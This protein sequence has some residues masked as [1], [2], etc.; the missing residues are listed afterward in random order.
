M[1]SLCGMLG[2]D[3]HWTE[4]SGAPAVF[5][6][7]SETHTRLRERQARTRLV[8]IVLA[9][10]GLKLA[11]WS[12]NAYLLSSRTGRTSI[13]DNLSQLWSEAEKLCGR[14]CDPLDERLIVSLRGATG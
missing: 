9:H 3:A 5:A 4:S 10:Y 7:R 12:G 8:N 1:C 13:V 6:N 14:P 11:D 2:A